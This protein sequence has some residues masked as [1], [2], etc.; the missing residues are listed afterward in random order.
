M[1][2]HENDAVAIAAFSLIEGVILYSSF[3]FL[4]H[5]QSQGKNKLANVVRGIN[6][7]VR[8]ENLHSLAGA[9]AFKLKVQELNEEELGLVEKSD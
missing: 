2:N 1:V 9:W 5:Y 4:K 8:D 6:F 3:A 7:S